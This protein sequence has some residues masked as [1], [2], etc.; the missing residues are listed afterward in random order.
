MR[1]YRLSPQAELSLEDIIR[2][3]IELFFH[4]SRDLQAILS[5]LG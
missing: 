3:T 4:G 5:D 2:W 1:G